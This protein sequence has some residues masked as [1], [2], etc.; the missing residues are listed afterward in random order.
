MPGGAQADHASARPGPGEWLR[1]LGSAA[2][3]VAGS[4]VG[5]A[6]LGLPP[7]AARS[8]GRR[9][10]SSGGFTCRKATSNAKS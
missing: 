8:S 1:A 9:Y 3:R 7:N 5:L 4:P 2:C 6:G 10:R